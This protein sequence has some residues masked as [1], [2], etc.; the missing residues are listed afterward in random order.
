MQEG[1][2]SA[3]MASQQGYVNYTQDEMREVALSKAERL[4]AM[5]WHAYKP[6]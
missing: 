1:W 4:E 2:Y 3:Y 5:G 6:Q